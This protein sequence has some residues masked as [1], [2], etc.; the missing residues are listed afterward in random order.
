MHEEMLEFRN[1]NQSCG[2]NKD[3]ETMAECLALKK[4]EFS[5]RRSGMC[6]E[7]EEQAEKWEE[8]F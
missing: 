1:Y 4:G 3:T 8:H 2:Q 6:S 5:L 7:Q